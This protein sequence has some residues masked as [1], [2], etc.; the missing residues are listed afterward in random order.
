MV[1][2]SDAGASERHHL[3]VLGAGPKAVAIAAKRRVL[4][5]LGIGVPELLVIEPRE[6]GAHW[7]GQHGYTDGSLPLGTPPE[8]DIGFP[9]A[10]T[11]F[12]PEKNSQVNGEMLKFSW[13]AFHVLKPGQSYAEWIDRGRPNPRHEHWAE[14]LDWVAS[15][16]DLSV[17]PCGVNAIDIADSRWALTL[18]SGDTVHTDGLVITSPGPPRSDIEVRGESSW[19]FDGRDFWLPKTRKRLEERS[20]NATD[21]AACVIGSGETAAAIVV[22]LSTLLP[23]SSS[24]S[25][26]SRE[27]IIYTRGESFDENR[28]YSSPEAWRLFPREVREEFVE[29]TDR[30]VFSVTNKSILNRAQNVETVAGNVKYID[31]EEEKLVLE[32]TPGEGSEKFDIVVDATGFRPNWFIELLTDEAWALIGEGLDESFHHDARMPIADKKLAKALSQVIGPDLAVT[33]LSPPLHLP[34]LA[35][36]TQGPGFP[37]LSCLGLLS[38]RILERHCTLREG[39]PAGTPSAALDGTGP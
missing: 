29:R 36:M 12:G 5:Q 31:A 38:D 26:V 17:S 28:L 7:K 25:V 15:E 4:E 30:G 3:T 11:S 21:F 37:N 10:S 13:A 22:Q 14:Y 19:I 2:G 6:I 20:K 24:I 8:K 23:S 1:R 9:Y 18:S 33:D 16:I 39:A 27:G 35:A 32:L 34:M